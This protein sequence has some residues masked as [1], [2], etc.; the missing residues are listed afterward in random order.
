MDI[1]FSST[2]STNTS[3]SQY[4]RRTFHS[5]NWQQQV[6]S[7]LRGL[8]IEEEYTVVKRLGFSSKERNVLLVEDRSKKLL[9]LSLFFLDQSEGFIHECKRNTLL[10]GCHHHIQMLGYSALR[11][12]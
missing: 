10:K 11:E 3:H 9:V 4:S 7:D 12:G 2:Q 8:K 1:S 6:V 5:P